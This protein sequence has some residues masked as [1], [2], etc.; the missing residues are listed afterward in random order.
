M[1]PTAQSC[2]S[3]A[4]SYLQQH[5]KHKT[6]AYDSDLAVLDVAAVEYIISAAVFLFKNWNTGGVIKSPIFK[7]TAVSGRDRRVRFAFP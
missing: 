5:T 3:P 4:L 1:I 7:D 2:G 6:V